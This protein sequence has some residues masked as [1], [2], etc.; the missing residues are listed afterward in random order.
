MS[1][2]IDPKIIVMGDKILHDFSSNEVLLLVTYLMNHYHQE[3]ST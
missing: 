3:K 1:P 2:E